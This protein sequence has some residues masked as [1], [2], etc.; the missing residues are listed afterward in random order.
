MLT[1]SRSATGRHLH[2][3]RKQRL[4]A[5]LVTLEHLGPKAALAIHRHGERKRVDAGLELPRAVPIAVARTRLRAHVRARLQVL[6]D[7]RVQQPVQCRLDDLTQEVR[8][9]DQR[10]TRAGRQSVKLT[11]LPRTI[12]LAACRTASLGLGIVHSCHRFRAG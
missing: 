7:L 1:P 3:A 10:L 5:A 2:Q 12:V 4:L 6:R 8:V 11:P 9:I